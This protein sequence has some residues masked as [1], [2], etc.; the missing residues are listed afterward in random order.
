MEYGASAWGNLTELL[1]CMRT[2]GE[3][4]ALATGGDGGVLGFALVI[5]LA[6]N[7]GGIILSYQGLVLATDAAATRLA[8]KH[9]L[10]AVIGVVS[11]CLW[12]YLWL[13]YALPECAGHTVLTW[14]IISPLFTLV[15]MVGFI[16][17][18][19]AIAFSAENLA[20]NR[21]PGDRWG[22]ALL[23]AVVTGVLIGWH[24][25]YEA[26]P[27]IA[28]GPF[29]H[30]P[31]WFQDALGI[32]TLHVP[33]STLWELAKTL[34]GTPGIAAFTTLGVLAVILPRRTSSATAVNLTFDLTTAAIGELAGLVIGACVLIVA[35]L[36]VIA[37]AALAFMFFAAYV[38]AYALVLA[39][40][41]A[42]V[43]GAFRR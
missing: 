8:D 38:M 25:L 32:W 39:F 15:L 28:A 13:A 29:G 9:H 12:C 21:H 4:C 7:I 37:A 6:F 10:N 35:S 31:R 41:G 20:S 14:M 33:V 27:R 40:L 18:V 30:G 23:T 1:H 43:V 36:V 19:A 16:G 2:G 3:P 5:V 22:R 11:A 17:T 34:S 42:L 26:V 24:F